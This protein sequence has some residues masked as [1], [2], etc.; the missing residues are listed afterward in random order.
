MGNKYVCLTL[1]TRTTFPTFSL[2][3]EHIV[4]KYHAVAKDALIQWVINLNQVFGACKTAFIKVRPSGLPSTLVK[5]VNIAQCK[6]KQGLQR[7]RFIIQ[8]P[9]SERGI[10]LIVSLLSSPVWP[11]K[12][13]MKNSASQLM[14][15]SLMLWSYPWRSLYPILLKLLTPSNQKLINIRMLQVW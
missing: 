14:S 6:I 10:I 7:L 12:D 11:G 5:T 1:T 13:G 8:D 15:V 4:L 2:I 9:I 3:T